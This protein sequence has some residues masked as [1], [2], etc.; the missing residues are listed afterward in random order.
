MKELSL[1]LFVHLWVLSKKLHH[2]ERGMLYPE[3]LNSIPDP[4]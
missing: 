2:R 1:L 4:S 3:K